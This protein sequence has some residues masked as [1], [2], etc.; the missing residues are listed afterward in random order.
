VEEIAA[1]LNESKRKEE[2]S[3]KLAQLVKEIESPI[4]KIMEAQRS[5][6]LE[7]PLMACWGSDWVN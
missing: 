6:V 3:R 4:F 5:F 2:S 7:G 1:S